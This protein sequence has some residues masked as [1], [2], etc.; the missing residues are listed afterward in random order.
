[1]FQVFKSYRMRKDA[2]AFHT[3]NKNS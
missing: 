1:V 3:Q 2:N